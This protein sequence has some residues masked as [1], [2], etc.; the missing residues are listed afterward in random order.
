MVL[1]NT[2]IRPGKLNTLSLRE[3]VYAYLRNSLNSGV[4]KPGSMIN[5]DHLSKELGI[6]KTP[7]KEAFIKLEAERFVT[8]I[9][10][11]GILVN[12]LTLND[13]RNF[14]DIIGSLEANTL[15]SVFEQLNERHIKRMKISNLEQEQAIEAGDYNRYYR[16]NIA[17]HDIFLDLSQNDMLQELTRPLKQRLYDFPRR[18]YWKQWEQVNL[19]EHRKFIAF[20]ETKQPDA[21]WDLWKNEHWGWDKHKPYFTKFYGLET[22]KGN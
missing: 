1:N 15:L 5:I 12:Q 8:I 19:D 6:S 9:P 10:R 20:V 4:L 13:I 17:F 16:L 14:Y 2:E 11:K 18:E 7:L 3:Q 22:E 21:A